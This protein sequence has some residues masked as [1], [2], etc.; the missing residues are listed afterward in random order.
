MLCVSKCHWICNKTTGLAVVVAFLKLSI[1][2]Y[3][4]DPKFDENKGKQK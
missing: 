3:E 2:C 1:I 4:L